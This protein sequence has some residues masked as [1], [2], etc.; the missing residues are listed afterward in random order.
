MP[1]M[2]LAL[3]GFGLIGGSVVRALRRGAGAPDPWSSDLEIAAWSP[4]GEGPR[5]AA[6]EGLVDLA[7]ASA[8]A[9]LEGAGLVLL[10]GPPTTV[11]EWLD[12]LAGPL[13]GPL[14][15]D[16]VV[17]DVAS[18]KA[19][20]VERADRLGLRFVGGHPM[21]G[22]ETRGFGASRA[23]LFDGRPWVIVPGRGADE[24]AVGLVE[25][26]ARAVGAVPVRMAAPEHDLA[27]AA[28]S[29]LPLL[30]SVA[31]AETVLGRPGEP[32]P[33]GTETALRLAAGGWRDA[34]RLARGDPAMGAGIV[35]TNRAAVAEGL[36]R[37][38]LVVED[39]LALLEADP[40]DEAAVAARLAATRARLEGGAD[41]SGPPD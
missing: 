26:L 37:F 16:A 5:R 2:R 41:D 20:I 40:V 9:A 11:L 4:S 38:R 34:T 8:E 3:V 28:I 7:P 21:A 39:W 27:V 6:E 22:R 30:A 19:A 32:V 31:L 12:R 33:F 25:G 10:A 14:G 1:S 18:T 24:P 13:A 15:P 23:D 29:H 17:T 36:R 35:A